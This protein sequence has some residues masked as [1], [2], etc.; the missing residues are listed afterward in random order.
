[1][2]KFITYVSLQ[3]EGQLKPV[4]YVPDFNKK[5]ALDRAVCYPV[6]ALVNGY[7]QE[8]ERIQLIVIMEENNADCERN[9]KILK[10]EVA[11]AA[12]DQK[13]LFQ[14]DQDVFQIYYPKEESAESHLQIYTNLIHLLQD[15][16]EVYTCITYGTKPVPIVEMMALNFAYKAR[17]NVSIGCIVYGKMNRK[18]TEI[19]PYIYDVTAL[20]YMNQI[21]DT[22]AEQ[23]VKNPERLIR[24]MLQLED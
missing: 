11:Q 22:L 5:L 6:T 15:G 14:E 1:M 12:Q 10:E 4:Q 19:F 7:A 20:F 9:L 21:S 3:P 16:D 23:H 8:G 2:K 24:T 13:A 17:K 18:G